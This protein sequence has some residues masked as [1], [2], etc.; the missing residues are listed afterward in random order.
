MSIL[1]D[2]VDRCELEMDAAIKELNSLMK[3]RK[4]LDQDSMRMDSTI[5][6]DD[7]DK[8]DSRI[9]IQR[10]VAAKRCHDYSVA[11]AALEAEKRREK[12]QSREAEHYMERE[13]PLTKGIETDELER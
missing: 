13:Q 1:S 9:E 6:R 11:A 3:R 8:L 5:E 4:E 2:H 10:S 7:F 12:E